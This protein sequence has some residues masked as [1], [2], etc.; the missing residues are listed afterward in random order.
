[1]SHL[2]EVTQ[3]ANRG[4][5]NH[6]R[7][8]VLPAKEKDTRPECQEEPSPGVGR[9]VIKG[10]VPHADHTAGWLRPYGHCTAGMEAKGWGNLITDT[11]CPRISDLGDYIM[12]F[13]LFR[14]VHPHPA[15][16]CPPRQMVPSPHLPLL[17][18]ASLHPLLLFPLLLKGGAELSMLALPSS[19]QTLHPMC[20]EGVT[21]ILSHGFPCPQI[22]RTRTWGAESQQMYVRSL[23]LAMAWLQDPSRASEPESGASRA[24]HK[25]LQRCAEGL[26][27]SFMREKCAFSIAGEIACVGLLR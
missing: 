10:L 11:L 9:Q 27:A 6:N 21:Q 17:H 18:A 26:G 7:R 1:M 25:T 5:S 8:H 13:K 19:L 4:A 12:V 3:L 24:E 20:G 22:Q 2:L 14:T 16:Y 15:P 23:L